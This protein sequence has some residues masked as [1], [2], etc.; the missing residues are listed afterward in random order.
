MP[1]YNKKDNIF[2]ITVN[3][4][5]KPISARATIISLKENEKK[6]EYETTLVKCSC[7]RF[8]FAKRD[9]PHPVICK[10]MLALAMKVGAI[11]VDVAEVLKRGL[12]K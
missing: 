9:E 10:H 6:D 5:S 8:K 7:D 11:N 4:R 12:K 1:L 3:K 2:K